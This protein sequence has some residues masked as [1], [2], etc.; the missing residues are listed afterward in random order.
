[1]GILGILFII[2]LAYL[3]SSSKK[4]IN[5]TLLIWGIGLQFIIGII[6]IPESFFNKWLVATFDFSQSPGAVFF[7]FIQNAVNKLLGFSLVGMQFVLG[8]NPVTE[9]LFT[10]FIFTG[11]PVIIFFSALIAILYHLGIMQRIINFLA[12]IMVKTMKTSGAES[13]AVSSNIFLGMIEAVLSI[14][15]FL[16]KLTRSELFAVMVS[17]MATIAGSV[18]AVY[19]TILKGAGIEN[20]A[21]HLLTASVMSAPAAFVLA[22]VL[23]PETEES[24]TKGYIR[25]DIPKE[26]DNII[27]AAA[28][29][30]SA[31]TK[32]AINV[33][34][35]LI[36]F[37]GIIS[38]ANYLFQLPQ[39]WF[40]IE[41]A[42]SLEKLSGYIMA[43]MAYLLGIPWENASTAGMLMSE[44]FII[45]EWIAYEHLAKLPAGELTDHSKLILSYALCGF[46]NF[47]SVGIM[48]GGIGSLAPER[49]K[50]LARLGLKAMFGGLLA[51]FMTGAVAGIIL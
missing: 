12:Y 33:L 30:A 36:A 11:L 8:F 43:P 45:N 21:G 13:L 15:P 3:F 9:K 2:A 35:T 41:E 39:G 20:A 1:M 26:T 5:W 10:N 44:K 51:G 6:V 19:I 48:I 7:D 34:G 23:I 49:M 22:K 37:V 16:S 38:L 17:G 24:E 32:L 25:H 46:A 31:G 47:G 42:Y 29:G 28:L 50:D 27:D 18:L 14:K 40:G 4:N